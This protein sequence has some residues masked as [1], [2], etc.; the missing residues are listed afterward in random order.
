M[1]KGITLIRLLGFNDY[2]IVLFIISCSVTTASRRSFNMMLFKL[3]ST[4]GSD[5][6]IEIPQTAVG[7]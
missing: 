4:H 7:I 2:S 6:S 1:V 3:I 5:F